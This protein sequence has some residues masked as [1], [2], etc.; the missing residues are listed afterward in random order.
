[1]GGFYVKNLP[2]GETRGRSVVRCPCRTGESSR[3]LDQLQV[4]AWWLL[5]SLSVYQPA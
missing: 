4:E 2:P 5:A 1:M 3:A